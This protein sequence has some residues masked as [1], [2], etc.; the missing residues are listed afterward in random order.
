MKAYELIQEVSLIRGA[1]FE[2]E[3]INGGWRR[4]N[5]LPDQ[6]DKV[7]GCC[8]LGFIKLLYSGTPEGLDV[9]KYV[10]RKVREL[11]F[12]NIVAFGDVATKEQVFNFFRGVNV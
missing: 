10:M 4:S 8:A 9:L 6:D 11:G 5:E 12:P 2:F 7:T 3:G 1:N